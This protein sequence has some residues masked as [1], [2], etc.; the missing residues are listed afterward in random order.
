LNITIIDTNTSFFTQTIA[1]LILDIILGNKNISLEEFNNIEQTYMILS[2]LIKNN[3]ISNF[4]KDIVLKGKDVIYQIT[5]TENQKN[6]LN[7]ETSVIDLGECEKII[8]RNISYE[9]DPTPLIILKIDVKKENLKSTLVEYEVYNPNTKDTI[10]L[11]ICSNTRISITAPIDLS[12]E[13]TSL[14]ESV[15]EQGYDIFDSNNSFYQDFCTPFTSENG[16]DV[17]IADRKS[18]YFNEDIILCEDFC[19]YKGINTQTKKVICQ[20]SVKTSVSFDTN[21]FNMDKFLEG[22]YEVKAYTNYQV[23]FCYKLVFSKK[24]EKTII[25]F[26]IF[27]IYL[28]FNNYLLS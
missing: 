16:T 11:D 6:A 21:H 8:K 27:F 14:Y 26:I 15:S 4:T 7:S 17:I 22:F 28:I 13:E 2:S 10:N 24:D 25:A 20:C 23:L 12:K 9:N 1:S 18:Y 3:N 19:S 5:T